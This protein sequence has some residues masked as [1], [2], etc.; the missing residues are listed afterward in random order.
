VAKRLAA[1]DDALKVF[2]SA[3]A[4]DQFASAV[5]EIKDA[6]PPALFISGHTSLAILYDVLSDGIHDLSDKECLAHAGTVR[7]LLIALADRISE[8]SKDEAKVQE[9]I[10]AFLNRKRPR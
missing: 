2:V 6:L 5:K 1:S 4:Q 7:T 10:G 8:I 9:A 3:K